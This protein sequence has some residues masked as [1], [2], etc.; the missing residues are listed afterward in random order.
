MPPNPRWSASWVSHL[1]NDFFYWLVMS[2]SLTFVIFRTS[3]CHG[4]V[5]ALVSFIGLDHCIGPSVWRYVTEHAERVTAT[6]IIIPIS[7]CRAVIVPRPNISHFLLSN[8]ILRLIFSSQLTQP[9]SD[10]PSNAPWF[11]NRLPRYISFV[12]TYLL[13]VVAL[14]IDGRRLSVYPSG[15]HVPEPKSSTEWYRKLKSS[16]MEAHDTGDPWPHLEV[17]RSNVKVT[18]PINVVT[19]NQPYLRNAKAYE[20]QTWYTDGI[21]WPASLTCTGNFKLKALQFTNCR[22][23]VILCRPHDRP[24]SL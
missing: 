1:S 11:F 18:R 19:K 16:R 14:C 13:I 17:E 2:P 5:A 21:R 12:L 23:G 15:C 10:P 22:G 7:R 24:H 8:A 3:K 6:P 20:L 4:N 9:P